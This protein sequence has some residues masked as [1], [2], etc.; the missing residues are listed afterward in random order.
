M[1]GTTSRRRIGDFACGTIGGVMVGCLFAGAGVVLFTGR[2]LV[3]FPQPACLAAL[4]AISSMGARLLYAAY[5]ACIGC[6]AFVLFRFIQERLRGHRWRQ[7]V[8]EVK[9]LPS[10][11]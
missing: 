5:Y 2:V 1:A 3:W 7:A 9:R 11:W 4:D 10:M 6:A 8:S